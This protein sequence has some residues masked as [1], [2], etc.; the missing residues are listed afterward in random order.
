MLIPATG[1]SSLVI[2]YVDGQF[3]DSY[4]PT[5]ESTFNKSV[6]V[7]GAEFECDIIDTAGQVGLFTPFRSRMSHRHTRIYSPQTYACSLCLLGRIL[8]P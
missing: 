3:V 5:I 7:N 2:Q 8:Y 6:K 1:K 4:Y